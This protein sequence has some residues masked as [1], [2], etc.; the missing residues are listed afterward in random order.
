[1]ADTHPMRAARVRAGKTLAEIGQEAGVSPG[2]LS[3]VERG[4]KQ[5]SLPLAAKLS[6]ILSVPMVSFVRPEETKQ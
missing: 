6:K 4:I 5:P 1:M 3:D 2:F